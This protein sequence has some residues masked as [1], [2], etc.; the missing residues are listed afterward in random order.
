MKVDVLRGTRE[1]K[2]LFSSRLKIFYASSYV[3]LNVFLI[4]ASFA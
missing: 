3:L 4:N 2:F 1:V